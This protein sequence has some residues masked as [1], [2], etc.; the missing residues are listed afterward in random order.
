MHVAVVITRKYLAHAR[1]I[2]EDLAAAHPDARLHVLVVDAGD[3]RYD[4]PFE[5]RRAADLSLGR[6]ELHRMAAISDAQDFTGMLK[7]VFI[8]DLL[9]EGAPAVTLLDADVLVLDDIGELDRLA[10]ERGVVVTRHLTAPAGVELERTLL[11]TGTYNAG[12]LA[13]GPQGRNFLDWWHERTRRDCRFQPTDGFY[14]EQHWLDLAPSFFPCHV[15]E[16][17]GLNVMRHALER[18]R[19]EWDGHRYLIDGHPVRV[20]HFASGFDPDHPTGVTAQAVRPEMRPS[21]I[22]ALA[23]LQRQYASALVRHGWR[24]VCHARY[25]FGR[26]GEIELDATARRAYREAVTAA[27]RDGGELPPNPFDDPGG[28]ARW[29]GAPVDFRREAIRVPRY[30]HELRVELPELHNQ[31]GDLTGAGAQRY[32]AWIDAHRADIPEVLRAPAAEPDEARTDEPFDLVP[33]VTVAGAIGSPG[34]GGPLADGLLRALEAT[35]LLHATVRWTA[36]PV[37]RLATPV[38]AAQGA[39]YDV[40]LMCIPACEL[41]DFDYDIGVVM[42]PWRYGIGFWSEPPDAAVGPAL[43]L[44][45][46]IW[47][48]TEALA[49]QLR[50]W[51]DK[52]VVAL[53]PPLVHVEP[54]DESRSAAGLP[55]G[56]IVGAAIDLDRASAGQLAV[57]EQMLAAH[58]AAVEGGLDA[59]LALV[60]IGAE[61]DLVV[62]ERLHALAAE[63]GGVVVIEVPQ[64]LDA[65]RVL[66]SV[67][68][69][70]S[71]HRGPVAGPGLAEVIAAGVPAAAPP[72]ALGA[73]LTQAIIAPVGDE[74]GSAT[75][76]LRGLFADPAATRSRAR[77]AARLVRERRSPEAVGR[78]IAQRLEELAADD[79]IPVGP[80]GERPEQV[81]EARG[82]RT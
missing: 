39:I 65:F 79:T 48:S 70:L 8:R 31:F 7:S 57:A 55:A 44:L 75:D 18:R 74:P 80:R 10:R 37:S 6:E 2:A 24:D 51:T 41:P 27:E 76:A 54:D 43:I 1:V 29:L 35:D 63:Q 62:A 11:L 50:F 73:S 46:E 40:N 47:A 60:V 64:P 42:R 67:D 81:S 61:R 3:E 49:E 38:G 16:D 52:P 69:H 56:T 32:L 26:S 53:E 25:G 58:G 82:A 15:A 22:P 66:C 20:F 45:D 71:L 36:D 72:D 9:D 23:R 21:R 77:D 19:F 78:R 13:V 28:F 68:A 17:P 30:L 4:E 5:V 59:M 34:N 14:F 33:G 12:V